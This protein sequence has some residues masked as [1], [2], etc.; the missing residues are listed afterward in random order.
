MSDPD[1]DLDLTRQHFTKVRTGSVPKCT[2]SVPDGN[3]SEHF[4]SGGSSEQFGTVRTTPSST[5]QGG[6]HSWVC[7]NL[8]RFCIVFDDRQRA[9]ADCAF[10]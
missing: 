9:L 7:R 5:S 3:S 1:D 8:M 6:C 2:R 10:R 4:C